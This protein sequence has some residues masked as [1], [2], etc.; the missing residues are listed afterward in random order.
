MRND[1]IRN[2]DQIETN[3]VDYVIW[4]VILISAMAVLRP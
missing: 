4:L 2:H 3:W 1:A